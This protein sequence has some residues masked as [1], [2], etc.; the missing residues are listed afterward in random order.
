MKRQD[1]LK[2]IHSESPNVESQ[3]KRWLAEILQKGD[4]SDEFMRGLEVIDN[5]I[6][7]LLRP[8]TNRYPGNCLS[9]CTVTLPSELQRKGWFKSFLNL[10]CSVNPWKDVVIEDVGNA[11]LFDFCVRNNFSILHPCYKTTFIVNQVAVREMNI[12]PL[13]DSSYYL[14]LS[15]SENRVV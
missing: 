2:W 15:K 12:L 5:E 3:I 14:T 1:I 4:K 11:H 9:I 6:V 8:Y 7:V 13:E 10:C